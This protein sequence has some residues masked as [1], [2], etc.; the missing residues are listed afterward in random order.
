M[1]LLIAVMLL[2][3]AG[4]STAQMREEFLWM[5]SQDVTSSRNKYVK[6]V[7]K[8]PAKCFEE[9]SVILTDKMGAKITQNESGEL[10]L[11]AREFNGVFKAAINTTQVGIVVIPAKDGKSQIEVASGNHYLAAFVSD[12][13]YKKLE[14]LVDKSDGALIKAK[15]ADSGKK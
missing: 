6:V 2:A 9:I 4:C 7:N 10:F 8:P 5:R 15:R 13:L 12:K 1:R 14:G 3:I 11:V